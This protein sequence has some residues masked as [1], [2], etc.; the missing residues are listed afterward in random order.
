[1]RPPVA[2]ILGCALVVGSGAVIA[3]AGRADAANPASAATDG[4]LDAIATEL[5]RALTAG[6]S[7]VPDGA[8]VVAATVASDVAGT[9]GDE[10]GVR[11]AARVAA[12]LGRAT[13]EPRTG[14]RSVG[15]AAAGRSP[16]LVYL[17]AKI[18]AGK[19]EVT[20]DVYPTVSNAWDRVRTRA[21]QPLGH[22]FASGRVD[23]EIHA[24]LPPILLEQA[25]LR[26]APLKLP[27]GSAEVNE[28]LAVGCGDADGD[29]NVDLVLSTRAR[30][31]VGRVRAGAFTVD[32]AVAWKD[33]APRAAT[34]LREPVATFAFAPHFAA[35]TTDRGGVALGD[36]LRP[37]A[38]FDG[39]PV[40]AGSCVH[41]DAEGTGFSGPTAPCRTGDAAAP[42][43]KLPAARYDG[44][45][46]WTEVRRDG[47]SALV[48]AAR[49]PNGKLHVS[50]G[51]VDEVLAGAGAS[52]AIG[53]LDL[54][55]IPEIVT[56]RNLAPA[57]AA[58]EGAAEVDAVQIVSLGAG[59]KPRLRFPAPAGVR[60]VA[61][62]PAEA[63]ALPA[64]VA[65]VGDEV[66]LVR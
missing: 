2:R 52:F 43:V 39:V 45:V 46:L 32:R 6:A 66:W 26:K 13:A 57:G 1:M 49:E 19:L 60:A 4:T 23:A 44:A 29:G 47:Q 27:P 37:A 40:G 53:D 64:A 10:L 56:A 48:A 9:R 42:A 5:A 36:D 30:L 22:A 54:D 11:L 38:T 50:F 41:L 15:A 35:G 55:G 12:H 51:G 31:L 20:A 17:S 18:V 33:L 16:A 25:S 14:D 7:P 28:V 21:P 34:V 61:V 24:F 65:I 58:A 62:C 3:V 8:K 59:G 63:R